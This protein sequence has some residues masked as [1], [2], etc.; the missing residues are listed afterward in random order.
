[1]RQHAGHRRFA[2]TEGGRM[3]LVAPLCEPG[4]LICIFKGAQTPMLLRRSMVGSEEDV[5]MELDPELWQKWYDEMYPFDLVGPA[6]TSVSISAEKFKLVGEC[7]VHGIMLGEM[8]SG[9]D[10]EP[11]MEK[12]F[13]ESFF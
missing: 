5:Q 11:A 1:M 3:A 8:L 13:C 7:Y 9:A 10:G 12:R 2:V 6:P 4:D